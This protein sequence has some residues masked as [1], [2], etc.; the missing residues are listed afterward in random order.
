M[1]P[2]TVYECDLSGVGIKC[3]KRL[4][5]VSAMHRCEPFLKRFCRDFLI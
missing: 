5:V 4:P 2:A 3:V 1:G